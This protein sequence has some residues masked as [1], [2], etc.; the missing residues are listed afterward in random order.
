MYVCKMC[1]LQDLIT[2]LAKMPAILFNNSAIIMCS[3]HCKQ[4]AHFI[5]LDIIY[6][7]YTILVGRT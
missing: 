6:G 3:R 5:V 2:A 1:Y 7:P 4:E